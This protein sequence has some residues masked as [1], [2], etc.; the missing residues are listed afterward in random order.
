[1]ISLKDIAIK[2][3]CDEGFKLQKWYSKVPALEEKELT[4]ETDQTFTKQQLG[5]NQTEKRIKI[6]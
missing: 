3:L 1:M 4:N 2:V 5:V 6:F